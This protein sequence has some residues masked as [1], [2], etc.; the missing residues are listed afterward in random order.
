MPLG[1]YSSFFTIPTME[2]TSKNTT[3]ELAEKLLSEAQA[4]VATLKEQVASLEAGK[5]ILEDQVASKD[6][7]IG[8]LGNDLK[9]AVD[10]IDQQQVQ[11][12]KQP[13]IIVSS[14]PLITHKKVQYRIAIPSFNFK[15]TQYKAEDLQKNSTLVAALIEA[16]SAVLVAVEK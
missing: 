3:A 10:L 9:E 6:A 13:E 8:K 7:E 16:K 15:G 5:K 11:L 14:E 2:D 4:E 12:A 1:R